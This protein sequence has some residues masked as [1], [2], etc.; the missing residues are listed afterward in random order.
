ME[1]RLANSLR[2]TVNEKK[3]IETA[4]L[5][6]LRV[7]GRRPFDY[8]NLSIKFGRQPALY[9]RYIFAESLMGAG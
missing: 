4:L 3:F 2:M 7:D 1:Q 5:S 9:D 6:D 8:R